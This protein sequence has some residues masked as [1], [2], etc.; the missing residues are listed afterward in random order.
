MLKEEPQRDARLER[1]RWVW[2]GKLFYFGKILLPLAN[3]SAE[4]LCTPRGP[5]F[6]S[7]APPRIPLQERYHDATEPAS[8]TRLDFISRLSCR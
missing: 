5:A 6:A 7:A 2:G 3:L 8:P 1:P 4:G